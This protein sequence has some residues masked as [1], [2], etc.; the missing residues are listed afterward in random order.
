M[1][2]VT[3]HHCSYLRQA[4]QF[5]C[6]QAQN[7]TWNQQAKDASLSSCLA[8]PRAELEACQSTS[9]AVLVTCNC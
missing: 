4:E 2:V 5:C 8:A 1:V 7:V 3:Q 9:I 6:Q